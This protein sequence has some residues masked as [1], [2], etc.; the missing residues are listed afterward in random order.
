MKQKRFLTV[1]AVLD[2]STQSLMTGLQ[3]RI[4]ALGD[5]GTQTM[6][7]PFHISLGSFPLEKET[8]VLH[9]ML[10]TAKKT[11]A[12][13]VEFTCVNTFSDRVLF[14]QPTENEA[15]KTLHQPFDCAYADGFPWT[16]HAT[17]FCGEEDKV[18]RAKEAVKDTAFPIQ[19]Q[20]TA[21]ELGRFFP[22]QF[23]A[24]YDLQ[25]EDSR[26]ADRT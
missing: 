11:T 7:I 16:P 23:A 26:E 12:F 5:P 10:E 14:L 13:P 19:A 1:M 4:I 18:R 15:L 8:E 9:T 2:E 6:G 3:R 20:V 21:L 24:R 17:L 25:P 22:A